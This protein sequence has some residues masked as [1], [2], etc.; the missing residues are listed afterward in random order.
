MF[1]NYFRYDQSTNKLYTSIAEFKE[2]SVKKPVLYVLKLLNKLKLCDL[3][4]NSG[5][6]GTCY[7]INNLTVINLMLVWSGPLHEASLTKRLLI[8]QVFSSIVA[9]LIR[10]PLARLF[11]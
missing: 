2:A 10:Y 4:E 8:L 3:V 6:D 9:F 5:E 11:F 7:Q 1:K